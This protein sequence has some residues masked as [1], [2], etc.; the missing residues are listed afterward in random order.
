M[1]SVHAF[2][3]RSQKVTEFS[4]NEVCRISKNLE[5]KVMSALLAKFRWWSIALGTF[6]LA[7]NGSWAADK[8][9]S[10]SRM[11]KDIDFLASDQCEGRGVN[12]AG[13]NR[14]AQYIANEFQKAGLKSAGEN[15]SYFQP[16]TMPASKLVGTPV[17]VFRGPQGQEIELQAG[18]QFQPMGLSSAGNVDAPLVFAGYGITAPQGHYDDYS[19]IDVEGKILVI[20]RD[21]PRGGNK[22]ASFGSRYLH[23]SFAAKI[24]NAEKHKA[25]GII[26]VNDRDTAKGGDDLLDFSFTAVGPSAGSLP[27]VQLHRAIL[28]EILSSEPRAVA[29]ISDLEADIDRDLRPRSIP[30][31]GWTV[32]L[33][34]DVERSTIDVKNV[35]GYLD[36]SGPLATETVVL[37]AHYD[38]L[39]YGGMGSLAGLKKPAIHHGADDNGSGTTTLMEL[40]RR[41]GQQ[42]N[43]IGRRLVFMAFSGEESG[44][45]GSDYYC[46]HPLFPLSETVAMVNMDMVG[47][48]RLAAEGM[49]PEVLGSLTLSQRA[50]LSGLQ[51]LTILMQD[52]QKD[53]YSPKERLIVQGAATAKNFEGLLSE[54]NRKFDFKI[55]RQPGGI[56]PSDHSSFYAHKV[57]VFFFFTGDHSDYHRPSDTSEKINVAGMIRV[58]DLVE[59]LA[60]KLAKAPTRPQFVKAAE[61]PQQRYGSIPRLGV[62]PSYG[63]AGEGVLLN[64]VSE[65]GPASK[66]GLKEGDRIVEI[67][68]KPVRDINVYMSLLATQKRGSPAE[69]GIMRDGK[70]MTIKVTPE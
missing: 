49:W 11:R 1:L 64:G 5:S 28:D 69:I 25:A 47:R 48:L 41:F 34:I 26:F 3:N 27:I 2:R 16:F 29:G 66:A 43:R 9:P 50:G 20:L 53:W 36:G 32:K 70:K 7:A 8:N 33:K 67:A 15:E 35:I 62:M 40:A 55:N 46:K 63:D 38:H 44:L 18:R 14:A 61:P 13:I 52:S 51:P 60:T 57:P 21:T 4:Y 65:G 37:G 39:G 68:G 23:Q 30:I 31:N 42:P 24:R 19:D 54:L 22:F 6:A 12:T 10:E 58:A 59:E 45:L 17:M 56:G